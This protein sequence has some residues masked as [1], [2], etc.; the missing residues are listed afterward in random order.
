MSAI[1]M[2]VSAIKYG[3]VGDGVPATVL[4]ALPLPTKGSVAFNFSDPKEVK[5]ETEG[6]IDPLFSFFVKDTTDYIEFS[7]PSP[8]N[9]VVAVLAGGTVDTAGGKD[10]WKEPTSV[11]DISKTFVIETEVHNGKKVIYTIVN[12]RVSAKFSQAPGSDKSDLLM[13]RVYKQA[14]ITAAGVRNYAFS[15]EVAAAV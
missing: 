9:T 11:P 2:G 6:S 10:I 3:T 12:G 13:V 15:R 4:T 14:A 5:I 7:I 8:D 1:A